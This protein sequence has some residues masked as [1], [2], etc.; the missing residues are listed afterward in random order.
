MMLQSCQIKT[1]KSHCFEC[2]QAVPALFLL[3]EENLDRPAS[4]TQTLPQ[5]LRRPPENGGKFKILLYHVDLQ[6]M[7]GN[8]NPPFFHVGLQK[9]GGKFKHFFHHMGLQKMREIQIT[10]LPHGP[11]E[12]AA[13]S[14]LFFTTR[15]FRKCGKFK[16]TFLPRWPSEN[17][18]KIK[19]FFAH[20][21]YLR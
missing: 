3:K 4:H 15:T 20:V 7:A 1:N 6:R 16:P 12:N 11:S 14:H 18:G 17:G 5:M 2:V 9:N 13:N 8:A 21:F 10:F 19:H